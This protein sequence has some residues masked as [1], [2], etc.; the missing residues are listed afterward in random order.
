M[1]A[2]EITSFDPATKKLFVVTNA[3][4]TQI[5]VLDLSNP[6]APVMIGFIDIAPYGGAVNSVSVHDG[7]LA[8]A[9]EGYIK[10]DPGKVVVFDTKDHAVISQ[11]QV[12]A[13][14]DMI[15]FSPDGKY[16]LTAN[17]GEPNDAYFNDPI[18]TVS[19]ISAKENYKVT[20][21][22][23]SAFAAQQADL[24]AK[25]LR[26]FGQGASF[27]QDM[28]PEYLTISSDSKTAW[29]TL[30]ENNAIAKID[31]D[32][33]RVTD[34]FPL[35][36]KNY[37]LANNEID[38]SDRDGGVFFNNWTVKGMYQPDAIAVWDVH[39]VPFL[40]TANEGDV[41]EYTGFAEN[42]RVKDLVLDPAAFPDATN[43]KLDDQLGRLNVT[44]TLGDLG[45]D[46][47]FDELY[48][49][50]A[51]SFSV[52]NGNSGLQV[53]D[54]KN[55]LELKCKDAGK[56]DDARSDD[57]G[58]EPE[59]ITLGKVG[60]TMVAF[61]GLERADALA[62]YNVSNP[63]QPRFIKLLAT[64]DAPEGITFIPA[65]QSPLKKSLVV[66][67]SENDGTIK[68]YKTN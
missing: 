32:S 45:N 57:K 40:F 4:N 38:P 2:A 37:N 62:L 58:V 42:S 53:Y 43:L 67:S 60:N 59:G 25:G 49:F 18:G 7:R 3:G 48:S 33:K 16:I 28:E 65:T 54:S 51:R 68:I 39:G 5:D 13:L 55:E 56:Y 30:Q 27:A 8:A 11:V 34:I 61:V 36:F 29:I 64:G 10:T 31:I 35:G 1:G 14:P 47:D 63:Y 6:L 17:E 23:F 21:V 41:R 22:D 24:E 44:R 19:I 15:S 46:N 66:V 9:I 26:V 20:N 50:G 12:G 52:W